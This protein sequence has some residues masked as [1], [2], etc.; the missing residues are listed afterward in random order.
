VL[1]RLIGGLSPLVWSP[2]ASHPESRQQLALA[3]PGAALLGHSALPLSGVLL[4]LLSLGSVSFDGMATTFWWLSLNGINPLEFPGRSVVVGINTA[5]LT[6]TWLTLAALYAG[7]VA[8]GWRLAGRPV[9]LSLLLGKLV[10]SIMPIALA[11]H[12]CHYLTALLINGQY[13]YAAAS[14]PFGTGADL[15]ALGHFHVT[16]SFL[17]TYEGTSAIWNAQ[18]AGIVA[19]HVLAIL[20]AHE[21]ACRAIGDYRT[22]VLSQLPLAAVMVAYTLFGLWLLSTP[23]AG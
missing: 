11:F 8:L 18:A 4:V 6:L 9:P 20:L 3:L 5:G 16:T 2:A 19:G 23:V 7:S 15:L 13:A 10:L 12:F 17:N 22:A 1:F 14:D 21:I